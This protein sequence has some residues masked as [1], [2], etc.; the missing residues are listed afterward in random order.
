VESPFV[1][2]IGPF[3]KKCQINLSFVDRLIESGFVRTF[4]ETVRQINN[5]QTYAKASVL[6][7]ALA[8]VKSVHEFGAVVKFE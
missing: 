1:E 2:L 8:H 3:L 7:E 6:V 5:E 4:V